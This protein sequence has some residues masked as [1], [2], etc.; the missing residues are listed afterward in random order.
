[1]LGK[2]KINKKKCCWG[3]FIFLILSLVASSLLW[4]TQFNDKVNFLKEKINPYVSKISLLNLH[5]IY[6]KPFELGWDFVGGKRLVYRPVLEDSNQQISEEVLIGIKKVIEQR[7][8]I[9]G[10]EAQVKIDKKNIV[11]EAGNEE[12]AGM[13][14]EIMNQEFSLEF[15]EEIEPE[16]FQPTDLTGKYLETITFT[17]D[18]SDQKP[19]ILLKFNEEGAKILEALTKKNEGK[20]LG[21]YIDG[22]P[23]FPL[24]I[25]KAVA[26]GSVQIKMD[27]STDSVKRLTQM[28]AASSLSPSLKMISEKT[29]SSQEAQIL[30]RNAIKGFLFGLLAIFWL[31]LI[32]HRLAGL[33]SFILISIYTFC[34][35]L[36]FKSCPIIVDFGSI[37]GL[38]FSIVI[39]VTNLS[40]ALKSLK[41]EIKK[42]K[43]YG[44]AVE[45]GFKYSEPITRKINFIALILLLTLFLAGKIFLT[46]SI[47]INSFILIA[48]WGT[49]INSVLLVFLLKKLLIILE[50]SLGRINWLWK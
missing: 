23:A 47:F 36:F 29:R 44:I 9:Y 17:I 20:R 42:G 14:V 19:L 38:L 5:D 25:E 27:A 13:M 32:V 28:M 43:S 49:I 7:F 3:M 11:V 50:G 48:F 26:G 22:I 35:L 12:D 41:K 15:R 30:I 21:V 31:M 40:L 8:E 46:E 34:F 4:P 6:Q 24:Q 33:I 45:E 10:Q 1:M 2:F 39:S 37:S 18:Q 16:S